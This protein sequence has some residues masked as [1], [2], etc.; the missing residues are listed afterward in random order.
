MPQST[1]NSQRIPG[2]MCEFSFMHRTKSSESSFFVVLVLKIFV[3]F[4]VFFF[5]RCMVCHSWT[6]FMLTLSLSG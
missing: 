3:C 2:K 1:G 4:S 6:Q 5:Q